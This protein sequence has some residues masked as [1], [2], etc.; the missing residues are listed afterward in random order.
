VRDAVSGERFSIWFCTPCQLGFT[1]PIPKHLDQYYPKDYFSPL[2]N[3]VYRFL[4]YRRPDIVRR[5]KR[6]GHILDIGCGDGSLRD[7]LPEFRYEGVETAFS[8]VKKP[9]IQS[10]GV[11]GMKVRAGSKEVVTFWESLEH[12]SR[13]LDALKKSSRA[14]KK[15]GVLVIE[16]PN[17][18]ALERRIFGNRWFH[19]D[20]PRHITHFTPK[21]LKKML[22]DRGFETIEQRIVFAPEYIPLGFAQSVLYLFSPSL[23]LAAQ[24]SKGMLRG[25]LVSLAILALLPISTVITL[26]FFLFGSSPILLTVARK[27]QRIRSFE[28]SDPSKA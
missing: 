7:A 13:P 16:C 5:L 4:Q 26:A 24:S 8:G 27:R 25:T 15:N 14:L 12:V 18:E 1:Y 19:Y 17:W 6:S 21:G 3:V 9:F 28:R 11:E 20:P 23:H 22:S 2:K 10:R